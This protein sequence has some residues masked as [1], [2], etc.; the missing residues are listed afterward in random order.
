MFYSTDSLRQEAIIVS[1]KSKISDSAAT[2]TKWWRLKGDRTEL[3]VYSGK[4]VCP[5]RQ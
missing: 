2:Q 1:N 5:C 3:G 4:F